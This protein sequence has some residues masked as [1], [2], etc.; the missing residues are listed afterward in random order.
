[1]RSLTGEFL[2]SY[3]LYRYFQV[4]SYVCSLHYIRREKLQ[5]LCSFLCY[6]TLYLNMYVTIYPV[7]WYNLPRVGVN[8]NTLGQLT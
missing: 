4:T 7:S 1:M 8:Y 2:L 5:Q 6:Y 3:G